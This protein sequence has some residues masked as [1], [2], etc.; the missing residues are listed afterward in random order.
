MDCQYATLTP[1]DVARK[2]IAS[3]DMDSR[4]KSVQAEN[5]NMKR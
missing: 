4:V 3:D 5:Q 1:V 2:L